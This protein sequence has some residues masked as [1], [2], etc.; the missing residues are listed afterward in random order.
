MLS[1]TVLN[2]NNSYAEH[3]PVSAGIR[4]SIMTC[5]CLVS[6]VIRSSKSPAPPLT[7]VLRS[8]V[9][10]ELRARSGGHVATR[11][12]MSKRQGIDWGTVIRR[13]HS[14]MCVYSQD[15]IITNVYTGNEYDLYGAKNWYIYIH[16][17]IV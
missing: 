8:I 1:S 11:P 3:A 7:I 4:I 2:E 6:F 16:V 10:G 5:Y 9:Q 17:K 15:I 12:N 13:L 14:C